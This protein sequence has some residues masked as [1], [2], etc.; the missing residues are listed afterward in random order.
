MKRLGIFAAV[1]LAFVLTACAPGANTVTPQE[2]EELVSEL[3]YSEAYSVTVNTINTQPYPSNSSGWIITDSD[4][5]GGFVAAQLNGQHCNWWGT[6]TDYTARVSVALVDRGD[7]TAVNL[8]LSPQD[9][10]QKLAT[11][12]RE[13]LGL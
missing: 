12:L 6:C 5:V 4:Q 3:P 1:A 9:E 8:S 11:R 10:A 2:T 7:V 13:R